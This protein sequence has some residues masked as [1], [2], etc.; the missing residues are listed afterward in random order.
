MNNGGQRNAAQQYDENQTTGDRAFPARHEGSA[1]V[2]R[3]ALRPWAS[4]HN[5]SVSLKSLHIR[6]ALF[7][8]KRHRSHRS[9]DLTLFF[10]CASVLIL[11]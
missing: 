9:E 11:T 4:T 10:E 7:V 1:L 5:A 2:A 8:S 6:K 3:M